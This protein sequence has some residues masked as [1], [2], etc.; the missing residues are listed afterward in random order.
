MEYRGEFLH[1]FM[2]SERVMSHKPV[3]LF[4]GEDKFSAD[5]LDYDNVEQVILLRG[6]VRGVLSASR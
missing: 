4:R 1:A 6:R 2:T 3:E 5:T